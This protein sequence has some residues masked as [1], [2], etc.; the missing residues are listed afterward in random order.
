M[1]Q[2]KEPGEQGVCSK[3]VSFTRRGRELPQNRGPQASSD[4][5]Q[6]GFVSKDSTQW[7]LRLQRIART[8]ARSGDASDADLVLFRLPL[9]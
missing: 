1:E 5:G 7:L 6:I 3:L 4:I 8:R 2:E 9:S